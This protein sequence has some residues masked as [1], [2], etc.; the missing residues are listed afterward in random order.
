M[1][2]GEIMK[3][4]GIGGGFVQHLSGGFAHFMTY[5]QFAVFRPTT[6]TEL[7][8]SRGLSGEI[9]LACNGAEG[10]SALAANSTAPE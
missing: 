10:C 3:E 7:P 6:T 4:V 8:T 5:L 1:K 2:V 9:D